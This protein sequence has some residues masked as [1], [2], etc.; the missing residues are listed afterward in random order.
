MTCLCI[1]CSCLICDCCLVSCRGFELRPLA[2][3]LPFQLRRIRP[4]PGNWGPGNDHVVRRRVLSAWAWAKGWTDHTASSR[5]LHLSLG[6]SLMVVRC[7]HNFYN[8]YVFF[9][10]SNQ[11]QTDCNSSSGGN[12]E[13][14]TL[15]CSWN[16]YIHCALS[17]TFHGK[18]NVQEKVGESSADT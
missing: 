8:Y 2:S 1:G 9:F 6:S 15:N 17:F 16:G 13:S 18:F 12:T 3:D 4:S 11:M 7:G 10:T 14:E 5:F